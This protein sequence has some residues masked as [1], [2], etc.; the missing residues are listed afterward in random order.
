MLN[1][2]EN[3]QYGKGTTRD[4]FR[5]F[6][7]TVSQP[8]LHEGEMHIAQILPDGSVQKANFCGP[9]T[10]IMKRIDQKGIT[11]V[12]T[13]SKEHDLAYMLSSMELDRKKR[14]AKVKEA[15]KKMLERLKKAKKKKL[16]K[17]ANILVAQAG[18]LGKQVLEKHGSKIGKAV[19]GPVGELTGKLLERRLEALADPK[20]YTHEEYT[21]ALEGKQ[22]ISEELDQKGVGYKL[23]QKLKILN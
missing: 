8:N 5:L 16:D 1:Y 21:R 3:K 14:M 19:A 6:R 15:D 11:L 22:K 4:I 10:D 9:G 2:N 13:I 18:I 7:A 17:S 23:R 20:S 12:D